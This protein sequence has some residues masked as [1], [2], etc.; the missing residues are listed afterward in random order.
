MT[1]HLNSIE[2]EKFHRDDAGTGSGVCET[3]KAFRA[4]NSKEARVTLA[5]R[6]Q[7][8]SQIFGVWNIF[9]NSLRAH[10]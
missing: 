5:G 9:N 1:D 6:K 3:G 7:R 2:S 8:R 10:F 4:R